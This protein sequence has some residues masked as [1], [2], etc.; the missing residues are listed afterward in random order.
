MINN[1]VI[2]ILGATKYDGIYESTSFTT[3]KYLA[4]SNTVFYVDF[5]YTWK[6]YFKTSEKV[7]VDKRKPYFKLK[8]DG[9][10]DPGIEN[11]NILILPLLLPINFIAEGRFYR[12]LLKINERLISKRIQKL[13][14]SRNLK[15]VVFINS[16]NFHYPNIADFIKPKLSVYHCV[17]PL[18]IDYDV[19]HGI[20]SQSIVVKKSDLVIC[21]SKELYREQIKFNKNT[22]FIPNAADTAISSQALNPSL[23]VHPCIEKIPKPIIGY[24]GNIE[25]RIN[26]ALMSDVIKDNPDKSFV[27]V[28]PV[29]EECIPKHFRDNSNVYFTGRLPY[30][31]M[32]SVLK[33]FD[34][35]MIPFKKD[36]VSRN[37]FP[38]KLFEYLGTGKPVIATDFNLDLKDFTREAV[39]YCTNAEDFSSSIT[40][41]LENDDEES[42]QSRLLIAAENTWDKRMDEF[43]NLLNKYYNL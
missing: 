2:I 41:Y 24:F 9:L 28:G 5:P 26:Y 17:D 7:L 15:D 1:K 23:K 20:Y 34:I 31:D 33:G 43:G 8:S 14:R 18:I 16:F 10:I 12:N 25:R 3:A 11:L 37:I 21:T 39:L 6:D 13:I 40:Y 42:K 19:K 4:K 32:P 38:L 36:D 27:F 29:S 35:A 22:F 30:M